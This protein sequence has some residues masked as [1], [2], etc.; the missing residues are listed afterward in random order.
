MRRALIGPALRQPSQPARTAKAQ[1]FRTIQVVTGVHA[2]QSNIPW[3]VTALAWLSIVLP[4]RSF[5]TVFQT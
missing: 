4:P 3:M 2:N 5:K 1:S